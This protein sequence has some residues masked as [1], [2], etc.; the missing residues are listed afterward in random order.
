[1]ERLWTWESEKPHPQSCLGNNQPYYL[2]NALAFFEI[3]FLYN[4]GNED[5]FLES[6]SKDLKGLIQHTTN[7]SNPKYE[8]SWHRVQTLHIIRAAYV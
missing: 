3:G 5:P 7:K 4:N 1:M 6:N 8:L 2:E